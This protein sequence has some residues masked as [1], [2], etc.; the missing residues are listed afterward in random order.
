MSCSLEDIENY[1][2]LITKNTYR[3]CSSIKNKLEKFFM[4]KQLRKPLCLIVDYLTYKQ[5]KD[6]YEK[7]MNYA[8]IAYINSKPNNI[9]IFYDTSSNIFLICNISE[10][11]NI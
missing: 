10:L 6:I 3:D 5:N 4:E 1:L 7:N 11:K 8:D 9:R 2:I